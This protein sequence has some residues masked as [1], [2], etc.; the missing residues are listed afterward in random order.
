[1]LHVRDHPLATIVGDLTDPDLL[2]EAAFDCVIVTQTLHLIY[3]MSAAVRALSAALRPGGVLL[4]TLPGVSS[5]D[6]GEWRDS[7]CWSVTEHSA[8]RL[9]GDVFGAANIDVETYG[10][11][12][13]ATCFLQGLAVEE[14]DT[15]LLDHRDKCY[16][17][18]V[19]VSAR[20]SG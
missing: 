16:P 3:D 10:N 12:Y 17:V 15:C 1:V 7:W 5:V 9:F 18:T 4:V 2:P 14:L 6:G 20:R 19:A 11:V 8:A 13:A